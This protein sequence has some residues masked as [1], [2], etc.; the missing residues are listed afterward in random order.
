M[1]FC[2]SGCPNCKCSDVSTELKE[3]KENYGCDP[4][5]DN[6]ALEIDLTDVEN[7]ENLGIFS[8]SRLLSF[9][10]VVLALILIINCR[11]HFAHALPEQAK[12]RNAL[13][14]G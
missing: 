9:A 1:S 2:Y 5:E 13:A 6:G 10:V 8:S 7:K 14:F 4:K 3:N 11:G 12:P